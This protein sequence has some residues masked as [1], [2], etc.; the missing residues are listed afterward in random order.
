MHMQLPELEVDIEY[1]S[2]ENRDVKSCYFQLDLTRR[3][4]NLNYEHL[5]TNS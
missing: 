5:A 3:R 1:D 2:V 4:R